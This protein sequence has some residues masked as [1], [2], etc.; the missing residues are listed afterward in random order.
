MERLI[1]IMSRDAL[2]GRNR[3]NKGSLHVSKHTKGCLNMSRDD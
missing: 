1:I 2:L 3:D